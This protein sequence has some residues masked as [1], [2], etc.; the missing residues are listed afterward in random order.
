MLLKRRIGKELL[1]FALAVVL[2][3]LFWFIL[4]DMT[5][6]CIISTPYLYVREQNAFLVTV[7]FFYFIRL[8]AWAVQSNSTA[9]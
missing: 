7:V 9:N 2:S 3:F 4:A 5:D 8:C 6:Q 1:F